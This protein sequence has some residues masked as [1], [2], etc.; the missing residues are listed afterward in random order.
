MTFAEYRYLILADLYRYTRRCDWPALGRQLLTGESY[1]LVFWMRTARFC[2]RHPV[3]KYLLY[4]LAKAVWKRYKFKFG[5]GIPFDTPIGPGLYIGHF[6][7]I[8]VSPGA[9]IGR[10]VNLSP[11][12]TIGKIN[13]GRLAGYPTIGDNVFIGSGAKVLGA[14][15]VRSGV[16]ISCNCVVA[17]NVPENAIVVGIPAMVVSRA[18]SASD[19]ENT[20]YEQIL[21]PWPGAEDAANPAV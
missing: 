9:R 10:N 16:V 12:V 15:T 8:F 6:G 18:G 11:G 5:I 13:R 21:G 20:E 14:V 7:A 3:L 19:V 1:K 4:P 2:R 17:D